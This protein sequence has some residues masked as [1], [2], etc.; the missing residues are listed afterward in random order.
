[1]AVANGSIFVP[2]ATVL[3][4]IAVELTKAVELTTSVDLINVVELATEE[5]PEEE[6]VGVFSRF[7]LGIS[8][9]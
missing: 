4:I 9:R 3:E 8:S 6:L 5:V 1:M 2:N 7:H